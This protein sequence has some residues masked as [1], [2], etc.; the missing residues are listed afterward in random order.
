MALSNALKK[1]IVNSHVLNLKLRRWSHNRCS[2]ITVLKLCGVVFLFFCM[3]KIFHHHRP[4]GQDEFHDGFKLLVQD[5]HGSRHEKVNMRKFMQNIPDAAFGAA[6]LKNDPVINQGMILPGSKRDKK[7]E[8][9]MEEPNHNVAQED[10]HVGANPVFQSGVLGNYEDESLKIIP[11]GPGEGGARVALNSQEKAIGEA[12]MREFGFNMAA[13]DKVSLDRVIPDTRP[14]ECKYWKYPEKLPKTSVVIVFHNEMW[15]T[16]LRTVHSILNRTPKELLQEI[17]LL[18]DFSNKPHL[19]QKL[20]QYITRFNGVVRLERTDKREGLIRAKSMGAEMATGEIVFFL[21]AHCEVGYNWLPPLVAPIAANHR[22]MTVP[23]IDGIDLNDFSIRPQ[24]QGSLYRG[25]FEW[26][27]LYKETELPIQEQKK[28]EHFS[29]PYRSPTHAGGL[30]AINREYFLEIG[31]YDDGLLIWGGENFELSFKIWQCGGE[32]LWVPCSH[33][34]H[35]YRGFMPYGFGDAVKKKK[36]PITTL[37]YKRVADVWMD[38]YKESFYAREP[39]ARNLDGGDISKQLALREKLQCKSF[40]W[41]ME[42]IAYDVEA[43][44]PILPPNVAWGEVRS[45]RHNNLCLDQMGSL[46]PSRVSAVGCHSQ[47][48]NQLFRINEKG[49]MNVGE[50]CI[51][52]NGQEVR[53]TRCAFGKNDGDWSW[54]AENSQIQHHQN[55]LLGGSTVT[56]VTIGGDGGSRSIITLK[57]CDNN[58]LNQKWNFKE[59]RH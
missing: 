40:K 45:R 53:V 26:G 42:N 46:P 20:A 6:D 37:N 43:K 50:W 54:D 38:E 2:L 25:I 8:Q 49:M 30:F 48:G 55:G 41:F 21:D 47:G 13:S 18:D 44:Y 16:L 59:L 35:I 57:E 9:Q 36:G 28:R 3:Y 56:C 17:L 39:M 51:E 5:E 31:G 22:T 27:L 4:S 23:V 52:G 29:E 15:T 1:V 7:I 58:S 10:I 12:H 32:L 24:Y 19:K 33:I 34:G 14:D 11:Q